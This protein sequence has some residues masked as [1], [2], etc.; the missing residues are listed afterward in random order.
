MAGVNER[1]FL[2]SQLK[3][4]EGDWSYPGYPDYDNRS[5]AKLVRK[6]CVILL[7]LY[8]MIASGRMD[9]ISWLIFQQK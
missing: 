6:R 2:H 5:Q 1:H 3:T 9:I 8:T 7:G 4:D